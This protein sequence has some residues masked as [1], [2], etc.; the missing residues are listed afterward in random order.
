M[1]FRLVDANMRKDAAPAREVEHLLREL[2][3]SW[4]QIARQTATAPARN[5]V[6]AAA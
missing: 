1:N 4:E 6:E 5:L 2:L 3:P